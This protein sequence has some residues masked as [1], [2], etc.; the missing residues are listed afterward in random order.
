[1]KTRELSWPDQ[2]NEPYH[3]IAEATICIMIGRG[4]WFR[5]F[6]YVL[7]QG[8]KY[9]A[10][11]NVNGKIYLSNKNNMEIFSSQEKVKEFQRKYKLQG[12]IKELV[13]SKPVLDAGLVREAR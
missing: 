1:M 12:A 2:K 13:S 8:R 5:L 7:Q 4:Q 11:N 3:L 9:W 6:G 10:K